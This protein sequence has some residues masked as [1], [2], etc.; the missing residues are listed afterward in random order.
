MKHIKLFE[1]L[2]TPIIHESDEKRPFSDLHEEDIVTHL[3]D[4][5]NNGTIK[6]ETDP[7][8]IYC[9]GWKIC[10][11]GLKFLTKKYH[12]V[13][14]FNRDNIN[15]ESNLIFVSIEVNHPKMIRNASF[16]YQNYIKQIITQ[17]FKKFYNHWD[18]N[19]FY[20]LE[21]VRY[22]GNPVGKVLLL[23]QENS[24]D[25]KS[26]D[27]GGRVIIN[28]SLYDYDNLG[29]SDFKE[30]VED[31][32]DI[33]MQD[34]PLFQYGTNYKDVGFDLL[35]KKKF[36]SDTKYKCYNGSLTNEDFLNGYRTMVRG[37]SVLIHIPI[38]V[39]HSDISNEFVD[40]YVM[41]DA[42]NA[43][44]YKFN[45]LISLYPNVLI[46]G[47][48]KGVQETDEKK[49]ITM[50]L[51]FINPDDY[52][53]KQNMNKNK[54][55]KEFE[56]YSNES[57]LIIID[58]QKS[59][60]KFFTEMYVHKLTEYAKTF[61]NVYQIWDNHVDGKNVDKDYLYDKNP[62]IP[63]HGDLYQFPN[64]RDIIEKRYNY[65]VDADFYRK[66]LDKETYKDVKYKE[67]K[68]LLRRGNYFVTKE[69]TIIVYIANKHVWYHCP[70][71]L[72]NL[73]VKL[74]GQEV[75]MVGGSDQEC[76]LEVET[77]AKA[78]GVTIKRDFGYIYSANHCPIK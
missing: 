70:K 23:I 75:T 68:G 55:I 17:Y 33:T 22:T 72:Y 11:R 46:Y 39:Y 5:I 45:R 58:V 9:D 28:E 29:P 34:D 78:L 32:I 54:H 43:F 3:I 13:N 31:V 60:R 71:K 8:K 21:Y 25:S 76:F 62:D 64:Q 16:D 2:H 6:V 37:V 40:N 66:I 4:D 52:K 44:K 36:L 47:R 73:F 7:T 27:P 10:D 74:K 18:I 14:L 65:D 61:T 15:P 53:I 49:N 26:L 57:N 12:F 63:V 67:E 24:H 50:E 19:I 42:K 51:I 48:Y 30:N 56:N 38:S 20:T 77:T 1:G 59:F 69:G 35:T 41:N